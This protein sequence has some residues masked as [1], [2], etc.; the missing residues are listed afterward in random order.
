LIRDHE[1][2]LAK[3][4]ELKSKQLSAELAQSLET[5]NKGESFTLIDPPQIAGKLVKPDRVKLMLFAVAVSLFIGLALALILEFLFGGVRGYKNISDVIGEPPLATIQVIKTKNDIRHE[6]NKSLKLII[7]AVVF[8]LLGV[9]AFHF[10]IMSLD[11]LWF[12][13]V[14]KITLL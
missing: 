3:Y 9:T 4:T 13:V 2:N 6:R 5:E 14:R 7:L 1:N 12:K 8:A 11:V 10:F